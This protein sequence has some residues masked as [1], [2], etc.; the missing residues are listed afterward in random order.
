MAPIMASEVYQFYQ[1]NKIN[2][3]TQSDIIKGFLEDKLHIS[4]ENLIRTQI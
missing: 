2:F 4:L 1:E 3:P